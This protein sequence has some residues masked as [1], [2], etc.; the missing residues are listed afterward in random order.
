[1]VTGDG[2]SVS[3][4][5]DASSVGAPSDASSVGAPKDGRIGARGEERGA[6][7]DASAE[8]VRLAAEYWECRL[9]SH[10]IE[11]THFG[12]RSEDHRM[13]DASPGARAGD[14]AR[15]AGLER[16]VARL[17]DDGL[18]GEEHLT[19]IALLAQLQADVDL[20]DADL[21]SWTVDPLEGTPV[22]L[23][24]IQTFQRVQTPDDGRAMAARWRAIGPFVDTHIANLV[25]SLGAGGVAV[26]QPV[27]RV[28]EE[29][30]ELAGRPDETWAFLE[31]LRIERPDWSA[32]QVE[33]LRRNLGEAVATSIRPAFRRYRRA[34]AET[35][36]PRARPPERPGIL[37]VPSGGEA[38]AR[39]IRV[40]TSLDLDPGTLHAT[41][42]A[43][44][45]PI[46]DELAALGR[47]VFGTRTLDATFERLRSD[48][49]LFFESRGEV[50]DA[51]I[52][53]LA[54]ARA[55]LPGWFG[56]LP[57]AECVVVPMGA[58]EERHASSA[59]YR[60]PDPSGRRPGRFYVNTSAPETRPRYE[61][62][63]VAFHESV[64]GHHLQVA[65]GQEVASLPAFRRHL[66]VTSFWE[67]WALYAERLAD[68]MGLYAGD[69]DRIGMLSADAL[70]ACRLVVDTGIHALG[71]TREQALRFLL[72]NSSLAR[73]TAATEVDRYIVWP[74]QALAYKTGQL[75]LVR[76]RRRAEET[77]GSR[78]DVRAFHDTVLAHGAIPLVAL[79]RVVGEHVMAAATTGTP[80][81]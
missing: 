49:K 18:A 64:P 29:L 3:A 55:A 76:L 34:L 78:F 80:T 66:G 43:E 48:P 57:H 58:H 46:R 24:N 70:R 63:A 38:Y 14:R 69:L 2:S 77:L 16:A 17:D 22:A 21:E 44:L 54:K 28:I 13:P 62:E 27:E 15:L 42:L 67:G 53:S 10:P 25:D 26:R 52:R 11:A 56:V 23:L 35:I 1:M 68:E 72:E 12:V 39:L 65:I 40:H 32:R 7:A 51:A 61:A 5:S 71:W 50:T 73:D 47:R 9:R 74:G 45:A 6:H 20:I 8:L 30:D 79:E 19:R 33:E 60:D 59:Y 75:E 37:H 4:P 36:L 41:G 31:P 81:G